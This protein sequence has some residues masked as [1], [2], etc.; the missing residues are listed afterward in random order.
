MRILLARMV[1]GLMCVAATGEMVHAQGISGAGTRGAPRR[2]M[3]APNIGRSRQPVLSPY[4][5]LL[6]GAVDNFSGQ[7]LLRTVPQEQ[8]V[9]N[10]GQTQQQMRGLQSNIDQTQKS[11]D[12]KIQSG[13]TRTGKHTRFMDLGT[14]YGGR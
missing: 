12:T 13:L 1:L 7:Y 3:S 14:F 6:P 9:N 5:N 11:I 10:V 2:N 4:L 8:F